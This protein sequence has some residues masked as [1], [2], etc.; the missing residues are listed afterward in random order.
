MKQEE[1]IGGEEGRK[2]EKEEKGET[3]A[4]TLRLNK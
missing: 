2:R 4:V 1:E 3:K